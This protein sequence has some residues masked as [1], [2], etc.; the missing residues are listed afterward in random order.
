MSRPTIETAISST[1]VSPTGTSRTDL[2][3]RSVTTRSHIPVISWRRWEMKITPMPVA[4]S[5]LTAS[6]RISASDSVSTAV[7][8]SSTSILTFSRSIS[9]AISVNCLCPMGISAT[10]ISGSI[11]MPRREIAVLALVC[12]VA[13]SSVERRGPKISA[14]IPPLAISRF[15]MMF[16]VA[17]KPGIR[18]NS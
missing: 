14:I 2:P 6:R 16:S 11:S 1:V 9:R 4:A 7:G 8:S 17:E 5:R 10:F 18:E 12:M 3:S 15:S 13:R